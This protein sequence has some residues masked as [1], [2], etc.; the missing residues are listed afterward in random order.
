MS[1][2]VRG[3]AAAA[4]ADPPL[5][6]PRKSFGDVTNNATVRS[7]IVQ[8]AST[9]NESAIGVTAAMTGPA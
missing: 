6:D 7:G 4:L 1:D 5:I 2:P 9:A 8:L 3:G